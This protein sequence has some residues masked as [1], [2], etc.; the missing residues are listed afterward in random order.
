MCMCMCICMC[1]CMFIWIFAY[2]FAGAFARYG[3]LAIIAEWG[4]NLLDGLLRHQHLPEINLFI[5]IIKGQVAEETQHDLVSL[6]AYAYTCINVCVS[7]CVY[8]G[9]MLF[10]RVGPTAPLVGY[11]YVCTCV[12][13]CVCLNRASCFDSYGFFCIELTEPSTTVE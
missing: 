7:I 8:Q 11:L 2:E 9:C 13:V 10:T 4:Y 5:A 6:H 12:C 3:I 1:M